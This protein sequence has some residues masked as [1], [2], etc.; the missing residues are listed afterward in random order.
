MATPSVNTEIMENLFAMFK[1]MPLTNIYD[2][3][4]AYVDQWGTV[5]TDLIRLETEGTGILTETEPNMVTKKDSKTKQTVEEQKGWKGKIFPLDLIKKTYFIDDFNKVHELEAEAGAKASEYEGIWENIDDEIKSNVSKDD[6]ESAFDAKKI[7]AAIKNGDIDKDTEVSFKA[8]L[9]DI[10]EEKVINKKIKTILSELDIKAK[11][12]IESLTEDE[13][14]DLLKKKWIDPVID[15]INS[16]GESV[17]T[18]FISDFA[19]IKKKY[20]DPLADLSSEIEETGKALKDSLME[21]TGSDA[22]MDAIK[23]LLEEL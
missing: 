15:A 5:D 21:L 8:M 11:E 22:D 9:K 12:K 2:I 13:V 6:D 17:L 18:K 20:S 10:D 14:K 1:D 3:Y 16:T 19:A 23:M 7:K 4:Q